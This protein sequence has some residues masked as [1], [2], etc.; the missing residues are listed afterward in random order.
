MVSDGLR[1][2]TIHQR[3]QRL[4]Y[5]PGMMDEWW[6]HWFKQWTNSPCNSGLSSFIRLNFLGTPQRCTCFANAAV[7]W[8]PTTSGHRLGRCW[9]DEATCELEISWNGA[10]R[11]MVVDLAEKRCS[12]LMD[13][14]HYRSGKLAFNH[15]KQWKQQV[16]G[17]NPSRCSRLK[18]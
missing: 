5:R 12:N 2:T 10:S 8:V 14:S 4:I 13:Y 17:Y 6:N 15:R 11:G 7:R 1:W 18:T 9:P 16:H 3:H